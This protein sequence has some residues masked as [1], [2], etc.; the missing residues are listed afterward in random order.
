MRRV[1][2]AIIKKMLRVEGPENISSFVIWGLGTFFSLRHLVQTDYGAQT[3]TYPMD[4]GSSSN[5]INAAR[6]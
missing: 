3:F 4:S 5:G 2:H 1:V 6:A